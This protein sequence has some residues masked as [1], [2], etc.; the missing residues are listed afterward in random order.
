MPTGN[1]EAFEEAIRQALRPDSGLLR[2]EE[3]ATIIRRENST[4]KMVGE[5][6][7]IYEKLM[8]AGAGGKEPG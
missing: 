7:E 2:G 6:L 3:L 8:S 1:Q 4:Q 5:Y